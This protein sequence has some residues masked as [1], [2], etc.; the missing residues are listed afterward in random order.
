VV[1]LPPPWT[2]PLLLRFQPHS[3]RFLRREVLG[4]SESFG[5]R[6]R[7][8]REQKQIA[9]AAIADQTKIKLSLLEALERDD[10]S[11]WPAGIFRRAYLRNY[12][13]A[14]GL[15]ANR[16]VQEF[17]EI[18]PDPVDQAAPPATIAAA[19]SMG[20]P[21]RF[22]YLFGSAVASL[23][24]FRTVIADRAGAVADSTTSGALRTDQATPDEDFGPDGRTLNRAAPSEAA[25]STEEVVL[26]SVIAATSVGG[27]PPEAAPLSLEEQDDRAGGGRRDSISIDLPPHGRATVVAEL[28][29]SDAPAL[30]VSESDLLGVADLCTLIAQ[31]DTTDELAALLEEV[32]RFLHAVGLVVWIPDSS[33][34]QLRPAVAYGYSSGVLAQFP[35]VKRDADNATAAAFRLRQKCVIGGSPQTNGAL[36]LP[37]MAPAGCVGVL[38]IELPHGAEHRDSVHALA[39]IIAAQ[40]VR[41]LISAPAATLD[42]RSTPGAGAWRGGSAV[43][44]SNNVDSRGN[45]SDTF[46]VNFR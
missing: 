46:V 13:H 15:D 22:R 28:T 14:V 44:P 39:S 25:P 8:Q 30:G 1:V 17:L 5:A 2:A 35:T 19:D 31:I 24:R 32:A 29:R 36:V 43:Y 10:L 33:G 3:G 41:F 4:M 38:A 12:A 37:L 11:H 20:P 45:K 6:L 21:T 16:L 7:Q 42:D 26:D 9:L 18:H 27:G 23:S 34:A 40:L